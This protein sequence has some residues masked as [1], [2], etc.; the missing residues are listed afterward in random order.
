MRFLSG[1]L[2][3]AVLG[4][5]LLLSGC[6]DIRSSSISDSNKTQAG[7]TATANAQDWGILHLMAPQGLTGIANQ[8]LA[9]SCPSGKFTDV[10]TELS[11]R[12]FFFIAQQY[13]V[14]A[15]AICQ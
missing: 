13:T 11:I 2:S 7:N 10:Q 15:V 5:C 9:S 1:L 6:I 12:D 4:S 3:V 14:S 8:Q